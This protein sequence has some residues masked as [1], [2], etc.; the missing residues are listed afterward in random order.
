LE[1]GVSVLFSVGNLFWG[2]VMGVGAA[3]AG[4][5]LVLVWVGEKGSS[6]TAITTR[7]V[8]RLMFLA[9]MGVSS[10]W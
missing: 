5:I 1:G 2:A 7:A 6:A 8:Y 10:I 3:V 4:E 9:E